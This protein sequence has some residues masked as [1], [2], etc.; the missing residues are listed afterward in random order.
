MITE[1]MIDS[2]VFMVI[3]AFAILAFSGS[4]YILSQNN[5]SNAIPSWMVSVTH[6]YELMLGNFDTT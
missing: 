6:S 4:F 1:V 5:P 3:I 2:K